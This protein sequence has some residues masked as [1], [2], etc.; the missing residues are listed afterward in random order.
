MASSD[1]RIMSAKQT[2]SPTEATVVVK[3]LDGPH[4]GKT[5]TYQQH[6]TFTV[7]RSDEAHLVIPNDPE[8][9]RIHFR[10][11]VNPPECRLIDLNSLN[12]TYVN[13]NPVTDTLLA[14]KDIVSAGKTRLRVILVRA[15]HSDKSSASRVQSFSSI[16]ISATTESPLEFQ[17]SVRDKHR[18]GDYELREEIGRGGMGIVRKAI[19][20]PSQNIVAVKLIEPVAHAA[21]KA[22]K[23]FVREA[24]I[25]HQLKHRRIVRSIES[26]FDHDRLYLAME[27]I[28]QVEDIYSV[29]RTQT[30]SGRVRLSCG[31][32]HRILDGLQYAHE[33]GIVHR[34]LKPSNILP[35]FIRQKLSAKLA[36]FG[37]A[38]NYI[39]SGLSAISVENEIKGTLEFM[40]PEQLIHCRAATPSC[41]IYAAG[42]CLYH[43]L[44]DALPYDQGNSTKTISRIINEEPVP[45]DSRVK[46]LP[47]EL[48]RI[49]HKAMARAPEERFQSAAEMR[50]AL[51]PFTRRG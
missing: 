11:E 20:L 26:G 2:I 12:G 27:Y 10:M 37:L 41:D 29:L 51:E 7:G 30:F 43:Y 34:D 33:L 50:I 42:A 23:L 14:N 4:A 40:A 9:S 25:L 15:S 32:I 35:F 19:H 21:E 22:L 5:F 46:D 13:G 38:K 3:V 49:V 6:D 24:A 47:G 8:I 48:S 31:I 44:S 1:H 16:S 39:N 17:F 36:D 45:I 28:D 18:V